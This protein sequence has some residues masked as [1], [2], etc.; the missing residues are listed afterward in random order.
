V[1]RRLYLI[2]FVA[3]AVIAGASI[4]VATKVEPKDLGGSGDLSVNRAGQ[5]MDQLRAADAAGPERQ[6]R[7]LRLL[8][9]F[10]CQLRA[11]APAP[12]SAL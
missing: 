3:I 4:Y 11:H 2:A 12:Q 9:V 1:S 7:H 8:D 10:V 5:G 6:G